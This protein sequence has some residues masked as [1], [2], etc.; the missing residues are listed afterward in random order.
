M[1]EK[2][3]ISITSYIHFLVDFTCVYWMVLMTMRQYDA[4]YYHPMGDTIADSR[5]GWILVYNFCAFVLQLPI[6][7]LVDR[8]AQKKP[9]W[10]SSMGCLILAITGALIFGESVWQA[11]DVGF[12]P[13]GRGWIRFYYP[14]LHGLCYSVLLGIGN[15]LFH[16]GAGVEILHLSAQGGRKEPRHRKGVIAAIDCAGYRMVPVGIFVSTGALGLYLGRILSWHLEGVSFVIS[17]Y[18]LVRTVY[19]L[20]MIGLMLAAVGLNYALTKPASRHQGKVQEIPVAGAS[21]AIEE[22]P[23]ERAETDIGEALSERVP[24][25]PVWNAGIILLLF[26]VVV[27]RSFQGGATEFSWYF[28]W[29]FSGFAFA[30]CL[31]LGK[32][33][34]G[35]LA[36]RIGVLWTVLL[37]LVCSALLLQFTSDY[38]IPGLIAVLL[39][40]TTMPVT[41]SLMHRQ[42]PGHPG[43]AFGLLS[44]AL[45]LGSLPGMVL[46]IWKDLNGIIIL[47]RQNRFIW[48][49]QEVFRYEHIGSTVAAISLLLLLVVLFLWWRYSGRGSAAHK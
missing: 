9:W 44:F 15:A 18:F 12:R 45:F 30:V 5:L 10:V 4:S 38:M 49:L 14:E 22:E 23:P 28:L 39:F 25:S 2:L 17:D 34:G 42:T 6:G 31:M 16:V 8:Y 27:L 36:D 33:L 19:S 46:R 35:I 48:I 7:W 11:K 47:P 24:R 29:S 43:M 13:D 37:P 21:V 41:L 32:A 20:L 40:Q 3:R 1:K 26:L